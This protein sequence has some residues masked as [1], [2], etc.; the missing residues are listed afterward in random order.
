MLKKASV[1]IRVKPMFSIDADK[2][3]LDIQGAATFPGVRVLDCVYPFLFESQ[4]MFS[5]KISARQAR[6]A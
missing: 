5:N 4:A 2:P 3:Q 6:A 1:W